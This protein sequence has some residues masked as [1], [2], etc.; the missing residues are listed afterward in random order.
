MIIFGPLLVIVLLVVG[1]LVGIRRV[2]SDPAQ[3]HVDPIA[4]AA[5][6]TPNWYRLTPMDA[7]LDRVAQRDGV[8]PTFDQDARAV[9]RVF[10]GVA[11]SSARVVVLAG[12]AK[13]GFVTYIQRSAWFGFPDYISV[14]FIDLPGGGSTIAI[15]SRARFGRS[16]LGV[17]E[18]RVARWV[19]LTVKRLR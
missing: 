5:P 3:W 2:G 13:D 19:D 8:A 7:E 16:D 17:N 14:R 18:E 4:A 12:S 6:S 9:A 11:Q 10:D 1:V 15:F